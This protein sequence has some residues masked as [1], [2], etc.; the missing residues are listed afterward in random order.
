M[1][2]LARPPEALGV[3]VGAPTATA[4]VAY[5]RG[6]PVLP[7]G[8]RQRRVGRAGGSPDHGRRPS[9]VR[10]WSKSSST[11]T[12]SGC[13]SSAPP[14]RSCATSGR[15]PSS[16][17]ARAGGRRSRRTGPHHRPARPDAVYA[18]STRACSTRPGT[19]SPR[20]PCPSSTASSF[21]RRLCSDGCFRRPSR[22]P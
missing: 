17:Q 5:T 10:P 11:T 8:V 7:P 20:S 18:S 4:V 3:R 13:A 14:R 9:R 15:W 1:E 16:V 21:G 19:A 2:A 22:A 6:L 12:S